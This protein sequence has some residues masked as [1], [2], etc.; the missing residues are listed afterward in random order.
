MLWPSL[1]LVSL[2]CY[3]AYHNY[4]L[5]K[6]ATYCILQ[7]TKMQAQLLD[8]LP[9]A[10]SH[11]PPRAAPCAK[12][13]IVDLANDASE[14]VPPTPQR[15][16]AVDDETNPADA[17]LTNE[18][19]YCFLNATLHCLVRTPDFRASLANA[20]RPLSTPRRT[21][22]P[23]ERCVA[24][25]LN[26]THML[27]EGKGATLDLLALGLIDALRS[28][29][30]TWIDL[31]RRQG[32]QDAEECLSYL[33]ELIRGV[34]QAPT[35]SLS[36]QDEH[37]LSAATH[38]L[39]NVLQR[40]SSHDASTYS[41]P[42]QHLASLAWDEFL[43][44]NR[45]FVTRDFMGQLVEGST[46]VS[47]NIL[48]CRLT[49]TTVVPLGLHSSTAAMSLDSCLAAFKQVEDLCAE[50]AVFCERCDRKTGHRIQTLFMRIPKRLV[51][52]LKRFTCNR[53]GLMAKNSATVIFPV[54]RLNMTP[55]LFS[56][57]SP[58]EYQLYAVCAH[59]GSSVAAGHYLA[60]TRLS[61]TNATSLWLR[62]NDTQI[63]TLSQTQMLH[64]T[65]TSAY[66]LLYERIEPR[67]SI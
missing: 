38:A 59:T 30:V 25:L 40:C 5:A 35:A 31:P 42:L 57:Q 28:I 61:L 32:Q 62:Y 14:D 48:S 55:Y 51:L 43:R 23:R 26:V 10:T 29:G 8:H 49:T 63:T 67:S 9:R 60:Y 45:S 47:C 18:S 16:I 20:F 2:Y 19:N 1:C 58:C 4:N 53:Y 41:A 21:L 33:L 50:D 11:R 52:Q 7:V 39:C 37:A 66:L 15:P 17:T 12:P 54:Q 22:T 64:E 6:M 34:V 44:R 27:K 3:L 24:V 56:Q 46:C 65:A 36:P 13:P